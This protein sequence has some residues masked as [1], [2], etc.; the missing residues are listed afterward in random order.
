MPLT[1]G[2]GR[3]LLSASVFVHRGTMMVCF[4]RCVRATKIPVVFIKDRHTAGA[5]CMC[6]CLAPSHSAPRLRPLS[7]NR[8][9]WLPLH[10]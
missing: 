9:F 7:R 3:T 5:V 6:I 10:F 4:C 1:L 2:S 8:F